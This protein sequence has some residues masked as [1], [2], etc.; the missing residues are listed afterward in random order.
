M[1]F[2]S[3]MKQ[4]V[5]KAPT[6]SSQS[7]SSEASRTQTNKRPI[8]DLINDS[9]MQPDTGD[10]SG[11]GSN[12]VKKYRQSSLR[13]FLIFTVEKITKNSAAPFATFAK[14]LSEKL[15]TPFRVEFESNGHDLY[16]ETTKRIGMFSSSKSVLEALAHFVCKDGNVG[17][18]EQSSC[19]SL[20]LIH[21]SNIS[22]DSSDKFNVVASTLS[23]I[24][25]VKEPSISI[26]IARYRESI[27]WI[28]AHWKQNVYLYNKAPI[29]PN[30]I[31]DFPNVFSLPNIGRESHT[32][33]HH[34][35]HNYDS[36]TDIVYFTQAH[37]FDHSPHFIDV[38]DANI[39]LCRPYQGLSNVTAT[40]Y[41]L[42]V[43]QYERM[44]PGIQDGFLRTIRELFGADFEQP[45]IRFYPGA[46]MAVHKSL[47]HRRPIEFYQK[48]IKLLDHSVDPIEGYSF[49]RI[50]SLIFD[51]SEMLW[52]LSCI[53]TNIAETIR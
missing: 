3:L 5:G 4:Y 27:E 38:V 36:L 9:V 39:G 44:F 25:E 45:V 12:E 51:D 2:K 6:L 28:P 30:Q 35:V 47:I 24:S 17:N 50:W 33:L 10:E 8:S 48:C 32:Y 23:Y 53:D 52:P 43:R 13:Y 11:R 15:S 34:I 19:R 1:S 40:V 18:S 31:I 46:I 42:N 29:H 37:P 21:C 26:V 7:A 22:D 41:D 49:E 16:D 14:T 20:R